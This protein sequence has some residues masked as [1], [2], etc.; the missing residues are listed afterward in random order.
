MIRII[1]YDPRLFNF[2][3]ML[4]NV[5]GAIRFAACGRWWDAAYWLSAFVLTFCVTFRYQR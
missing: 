1:L 4:L 3:L 5:G 2:V